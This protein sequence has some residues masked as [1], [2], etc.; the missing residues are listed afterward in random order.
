M[1]VRIVCAHVSKVINIQEFQTRDGTSATSRTLLADKY[2][3]P[4]MCAFLKANR[5]RY[6]HACGGL[7]GSS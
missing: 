6:V 1:I 4:E 3:L 7:E 5:N 2:I